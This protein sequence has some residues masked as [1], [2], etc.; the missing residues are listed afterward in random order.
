MCLFSLFLTLAVS[1][2]LT[3]AIR[4]GDEDRPVYVGDARKRPTFGYHKAVVVSR[5]A[6][7]T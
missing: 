2:R 6:L 7:G 1:A 5:L 3:E 4:G